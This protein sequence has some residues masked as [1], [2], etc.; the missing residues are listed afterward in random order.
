MKRI[1]LYDGVC[2]FCNWNVQFIIKRDPKAKFSFAS[3]Q[4]ET[5]QDLLRQHHM[6]LDTDSIVL[7]HGNQYDVESTAALKIARQLHYFYPLLYVLI[8]IPRPLRDRVYRFIAKHRYKYF[9]KQDQCTIPTLE[10]KKR[11]LT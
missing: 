2:R 1:I 9:G 5:G 10:D 6:P 7:F 8:V 11:F 3:L 4:S